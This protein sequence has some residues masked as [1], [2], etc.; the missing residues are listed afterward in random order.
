MAGRWGEFLPSIAV[1][2][3]VAGYL[4]WSTGLLRVNATHEVWQ[5]IVASKDLSKLQQ[6]E[7]D[8]VEVVTHETIHFMQIVT[9]GW[10]Y[11][12]AV[13]LFELIKSCIPFPVKDFSQIP[14][15][16]PPGPAAR[17]RNHLARLDVAGA[18]SVTVRS[19]VECQAVLAQLQTH[20]KSTDHESF[21]KRIHESHLPQ[22]YRAAYL[23]AVKHLDRHAFESY[24]FISNMALCCRDPVTS[25]EVI[26]RGVKTAAL[27]AQPRRAIQGYLELLNRLH[28]A[29]N[30]E[31]IGTAAEVINSAPEHPVYTP[32]VARL[33]ELS[34][35]SSMLEYMAAPHEIKE[36]V[37][38]AVARPTVFN[39]DDSGNARVHVP[40]NWRSDLTTGQKNAEAEFLVFLMTTATRLLQNL[41]A[42]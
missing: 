8:I 36:P 5:R 4:D 24:P 10:L 22:E 21:V 6:W 33:N 32:M 18:N 31:M 39:L 14:K 11:Q 12:F 1:P 40:T 9:T 13:E 37:A 23:S 35:N 3:G 29:G 34:A 7:R 20:W 42:K 2:K 26:C 16:P 41:P 27:P 30:L 25:F 38:V 28:T 15:V 17:I 19:L